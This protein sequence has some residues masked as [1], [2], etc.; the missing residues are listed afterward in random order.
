MTEDLYAYLAEI[1]VFELDST[2]SWGQ[3][4]KFYHGVWPAGFEAARQYVTGYGAM[5]YLDISNATKFVE[6]EDPHSF[7][8]E[9]CLY[10]ASI[11]PKDGT[12]TG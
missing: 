4:F 8:I 3:F 9:R 10:G 1:R 5:L 7:P 6:V 11:R 12:V 2:N